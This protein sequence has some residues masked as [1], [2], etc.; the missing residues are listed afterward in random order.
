VR[1][2]INTESTAESLYDGREVCFIEYDLQF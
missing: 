1:A 2:K